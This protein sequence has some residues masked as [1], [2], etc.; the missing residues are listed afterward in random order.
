MRQIGQFSTA[1]EFNGLKLQSA[2][3]DVAEWHQVADA[4]SNLCEGDIVAIGCD[5]R[6][7]RL[8]AARAKVLGVVTRKAFVEGSA[9]PGRDVLWKRCAGWCGSLGLGYTLFSYIVEV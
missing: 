5:A 3:G 2:G 7:T 4:E 1:D 9:P 6:I 8:D